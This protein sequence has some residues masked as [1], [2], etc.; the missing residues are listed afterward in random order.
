M[1]LGFK[2]TGMLKLFLDV[3]FK[4]SYSSVQ[5]CCPLVVLSGHSI[6]S[7][8]NVLMPVHSGWRS[9]GQ[10]S[11]LWNSVYHLD[12]HSSK[13]AWCQ[14]WTLGILWVLASDNPQW[15]GRTLH[16]CWILNH[17]KYQ[18]HISAILTTKGWTHLVEFQCNF[19]V[20]ATR[21]LYPSHWTTVHIRTE[22][23]LFFNCHQFQ[24]NSIKFYFYSANNNWKCRFTGRYTWIGHSTIGHYLMEEDTKGPDIWLV[25]KAPVAD[26]LRGTPLI[27]DLLL[28][29]QVEGILQLECDKSLV[30]DKE[31]NRMEDN[32]LNRNIQSWHRNRNQ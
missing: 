28:I 29:W 11:G 15:F 32:L 1:E 13:K 30:E 18:D 9:Q 31:Q 16:W 27:G 6:P 8:I 23:K 22:V 4:I 21:I 14:R 17:K 12:W 10:A 5:L 19:N 25:R 24:F 26:G 20:N 2:H 3:C 7:L